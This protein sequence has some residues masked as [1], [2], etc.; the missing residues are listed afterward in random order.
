MGIVTQTLADLHKAPSQ[1]DPLTSLAPNYGDNGMSGYPEDTMQP[2]GIVTQTLADL[3][4]ASSL[5]VSHA[6][7]VSLLS[8]ELRNSKLRGSP[9]CEPVL[10][11]VEVPKQTIDKAKWGDLKGTEISSIVN[12]TYDTIVTWRRKLFQVP[13]GMIGKTFIAELTK[14]II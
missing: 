4:Q 10:P 1:P 11:A 2:M 13:T 8:Q 5:P 7:P 3:D 6:A 14:T 9:L 12:S